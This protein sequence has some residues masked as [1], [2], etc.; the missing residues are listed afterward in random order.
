MFGL[1]GM[2]A[3]GAATAPTYYLVDEGLNYD[4]GIGFGTPE[5]Q[6]TIGTIPPSPRVRP[7]DRVRTAAPAAPAAPATTTP[8]S[9]PPRVS[10]SDSDKEEVGLTSLID[11]F[12]GPAKEAKSL[13]DITKERLDL[14]RQLGIEADPYAKARENLEKDRATDKE[15]RREAGWMRLLEAGLGT[16]GGESPY[17][18]VNLGK[19]SQAAAKGA[20][21]DMKE[22]RKLERDRKKAEA[23]Y[24]IATNAYKKSGADADLAAVDRERTRVEAAN[25]KRA[26]AGLTVAVE[27][28]K[29]KAQRE[30][31]L[32]ERDLKLYLGA[33]EQAS[34][35]L[36][37]NFDVSSMSLDEIQRQVNAQ[38][39]RI[40][41]QY[42]EG[43][44]GASANTPQGNI[45]K[46]P[47]TGKLRY[48]L[49][50]E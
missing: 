18:F 50:G 17:G 20:A 2:G 6:M 49:P 46:D 29:L 28:V 42:K 11:K 31:R 40:Y 38:A 32:Q 25:M 35:I 3:F 15:A 4:T 12:Y 19:G 8:P 48:K 13:Q 16:L 10:P 30:G 5:E 22:F 34:A 43:G 1:R 27:Q 23:D 7:V 33:I 9:P 45:I 14:Y 47:K 26:D 39:A 44:F 21:E 37:N 36:K 41:N 24:A